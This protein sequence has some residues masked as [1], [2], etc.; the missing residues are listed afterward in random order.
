MNSDY[1]VTV[2]RNTKKISKRQ[3]THTTHSNSK[4]PSTGPEVMQDV[5]PS[6]CQLDRF[7]AEIIFEIIGYLP[8]TTFLQLGYVCRRLYQVVC[9]APIWERIWRTAGLP[10]PGRKRKSH[11]EVVLTEA[12]TI[13][14]RCYLKSKAFGSNS[15]IKIMDTDDGLMISLCCQ[16]RRDYYHK[17]PEPY[18]E[19]Q[20]EGSTQTERS[21]RI[22]KM[23]A[24]SEYRLTDDEL[25][26]VS[27]TYA[28]NPH[29]RNA[30]PM[31]LYDVKQVIQ[32][33][34]LV[35]GGDIG[36]EAALNATIKKGNAMIEAR[37][38]NKETRKIRLEERLAKEN[39][40]NMI[41]Y[42]VCSHYIESSR[43]GNLETIVITLQAE[44]EKQR[45][46]VNRRSE[47][48][49]ALAASGIQNVP[50]YL[51]EYQEYVNHGNGL[52]EAI[53][54]QARKLDEVVRNKVVRIQ[55]LTDKLA[56]AG[57]QNVPRHSIGYH[58]YVNNANGSVEE[59]LLQARKKEEV[60]RNQEL[61]RQ[62]LIDK[63][64][65]AGLTLRSDS[66]LCQ[67]YIGSATGVADSI[68]ITM[69]EMDWFF[70]CTSYA[71][72]RKSFYNYYEES[73][74]DTDDDYGWEQPRWR[75][76]INSEKGKDEALE[77]WINTRIVK[78]RYQ[79]VDQ[80]QDNKSRPPS[81]LWPTINGKWQRAVRAHAIRKLIP[82]YRNYHQN[83]IA[84]AAAGEIS[85]SERQ[86][87][88][89]LDAPETEIGSRHSSALRLIMGEHW[90]QELI[91]IIS[92]L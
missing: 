84:T 36:I 75:Y 17:N 66:R 35:H 74:Y 91:G 89:W 85:V 13:C 10:K 16:C 4:R 37:R 26:G 22:T 3:I 38:R 43:G 64:A 53:L 59:I 11:R 48:D 45:L 65:V 21:T 78:G 47:I 14:E 6:L 1:S 41:H 2:K 90:H 49:A 60:A 67:R 86:L 27:V 76:S 19:A 34:R 68:V 51:T 25:E 28:R 69:M 24:K 71:T 7:P 56:A 82:H 88:D 20:A 83:W 57:L 87:I 9:D 40:T 15:P 42:H 44:A 46:I 81:S 79:R 70:R 72:S 32:M 54:S 5:I 50:L 33:A 92:I 29:Y 18:E 12:E 80:D 31:C 77:N 39:L 62:E 23:R 30:A 58:E 52:V 63:L 8:P 61:R 55:E 73:E